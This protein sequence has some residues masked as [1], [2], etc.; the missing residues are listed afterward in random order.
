MCR[1]P[2]N[3]AQRPP[4]LRALPPVSGAWCFYCH[5]FFGGLFFFYQKWLCD[6]TDSEKITKKKFILRQHLQ[7]NYFST[8]N[9]LYLCY[10]PYI[11]S[12]SAEK[13]NVSDGQ[14]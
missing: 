4:A 13:G 8:C 5:L 14:T 7:E 1:R 3:A 6:Q 11:V 12:V 9:L 2:Q 10:I